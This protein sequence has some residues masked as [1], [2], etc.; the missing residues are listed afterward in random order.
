MEK[1]IDIAEQYASEIGR[2][3][4]KLRELRSGRF[5]GYNG[6]GSSDG[7]LE[8][9]IDELTNDLKELMHKIEYR[10]DSE[11]DFILKP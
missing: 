10:Q 11:M 1:K 3:N 4:D 5:A 8:N 2:I 7:F 6:N 9:K